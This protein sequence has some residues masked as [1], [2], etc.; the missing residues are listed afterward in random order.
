MKL[1]L[2]ETII[3]SK[4]GGKRGHIVADTL[5]LIMFSWASKR[6]NICWGH[7]MLLK[8]MRNIF[9]S[10]TQILCPQQMLRGGGRGQ[11]GKHLCPPKSVRNIVSS[12]ATTLKG[13][14]GLEK[15]Y[16]K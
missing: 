2:D 8:E 7:K 9:V 16:L 12:F 15:F 13:N 10:R 3:E 14:K 11:T 6:G 1:G 4:G 5:L